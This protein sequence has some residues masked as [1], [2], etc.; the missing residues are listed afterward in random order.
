[1]STQLDSFETRLL[2]ELRRHVANAP[3]AGEG[4]DSRQPRI[5]RT[6]LAFLAATAAVVIVAVLF[7]PG[8]GSSPAYSVGEGNAGEVHVEINRPED[9]AGLE[10]ALEE[11]GISADITYLPEL[12]ICAPG[13][14]AVA[15]RER[16]GLLLSVGERQ[17]SVTL[18]PG[19]V[20]DDE[21]FV[22]A[23]SVVP[24]TDA[25]L[26]Q[27]GAETDQSVIDGFRSSVEF[28]IATGLVAPC[29]P[30]VAPSP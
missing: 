23:W 14:Y 10:R 2:A 15:D 13:R 24:M 1:M 12:Q 7:A 26:E 25:E 22:L 27:V 16:T 8:V 18:E 30:I 20:R 3:A 6:R 11:H 21:T 4:L 29:Q 9:A 19:A 28:D 5:G 17:L